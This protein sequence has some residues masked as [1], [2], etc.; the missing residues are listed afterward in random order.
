MSL[1]FWL[2]AADPH[3]QTGSGI[4][5]R[6]DGQNVEISRAEWDAA[7]P[8]CEPV[9]AQQEPETRE[10]YSRNITHNLGHMAAQ[11][12]LYE[13]LWRPEENGIR[14]GS[15][16]VL[17]LED[18]IKLLRSDPTRFRQFDAPNGWGKYEN[19]LSFAELTLAA[20]REYPNARIRVS[21]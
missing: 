16:A 2:E 6:R 9:I 11:S 3:P 8:G 1:D 12:G 7:L 20:C 14:V 10:L 4:F 5:V 15:E 21:R 13:V 18:G 19:L 17:L